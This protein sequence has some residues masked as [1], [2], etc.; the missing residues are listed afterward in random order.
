MLSNTGKHHATLAAHESWPFDAASCASLA[1]DCCARQLK[2]DCT[3]ICFHVQVSR[4]NRQF[5]LPTA[6]LQ[7]AYI[8][9]TSCLHPAYSLPTAC[10]QP[11]Y[12]LPIS[13]SSGAVQTYIANMSTQ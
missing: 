3:A 5:C 6:C 7:P 13:C 4:H 1:L 10:L 2:E 9:P 11:A 12:S 8:L